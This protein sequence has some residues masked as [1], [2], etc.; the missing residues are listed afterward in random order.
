[1][2]DEKEVLLAA[3]ARRR[4][5][6]IAADATTLAALLGDELVWTHSS[7]RTDNKTA[8]LEGIVSGTV[9]YLALDVADV[10]VSQLGEAFVCH[11]TLHGRARRGGVEKSL[12]NRFLS[13]W[14]RRGDGFAMVAWQ[15]TG[16][17]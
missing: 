11:G 1:M 9:V 8:F 13:V 3:D 4:A 15:S 17:D 5:A 12:H 6:M 10:V 2:M 7:G 16:I 14:R